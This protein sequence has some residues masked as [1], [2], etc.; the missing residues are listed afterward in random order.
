M[1]RSP[2]HHKVSAMTIKT[3]HIGYRLA[4][5]LVTELWLGFLGLDELADYSEFLSD[6]KFAAQP[7]ASIALVMGINVRRDKGILG[8][9]Y[10]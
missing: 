3:K 4:L 9:M 8:A 10:Q 7:T 1:G 2:G 6:D 5:W